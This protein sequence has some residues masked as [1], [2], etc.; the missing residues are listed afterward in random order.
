[1]KVIAFCLFFLLTIA[2]CAQTNTQVVLGRE[3]NVYSKILNEKRQIWVNVPTNDSPDGVFAQQRYPVIYLLDGWEPNFSILTSIVQLLGGGSGNLSFPQMIVVGIPNTDRT[4][5]LTPTHI[6]SA[7]NM[8][9][10][11][12]RT[13]GGG[14]KFVSFIDKE[15][16]PHIDSVYPT[17]PYRV[18]IGHSLGGLLSI[19]AMINHTHLFNAYVA[20]DPSMIWD[21]KKILNQAKKALEKNNFD[22]SSLFLAIAN[23]MNSGVDTNIIGPI[24]RATFQLGDY[25]NAN[26]RNGLISSTKYYPDYDHQ[27]VPLVAQYDALRFLF[28]FYTL[29]FP[30]TDFFDPFYKADTMLSAHY[31]NISDRMGYKVS[32]PEQFVKGIANQ[33][34]TMNQFERAYY[35]FKMNI[36]NYPTSF[37][38]Y[39]SMGDFFEKKGDK[40]EAIQFYYK[41]LSIC[42]TTDTRQKLE[43]LK[44]NK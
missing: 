28:N 42:E 30:Y 1:M 14:E 11:S 41:S 43:K 4:R 26:K 6:V 19:Y 37:N 36:E 15:L 35:F 7:P 25:L 16:I 18:F 22:G 29:N 32:P 23:T 31:K 40:Q 33:L 17:A 38:A 44:A 3:D 24:M 21:D 5:D 13:S 20:I 27:S 10:I 8:D 39:D 2:L 12:A 9:S 34:M